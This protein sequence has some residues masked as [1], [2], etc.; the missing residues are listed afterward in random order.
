MPLNKNLA[1]EIMAMVTLDQKARKDSVKRKGLRSA[2]K[3]IDRKNTKE[4]IRI[5]EKYGWPTIS[6]VGEK[7]S[8]GAWLIAQHADQEI[9]FQKRALILLKKNLKDITKSNIAYLTDRI[10]INQKKPQL[11]GTQFTKSKNNLFIPLPIIKAKMVNERRRYYG[12]PTIES[13][14]KRINREWKRLGGT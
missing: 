8:N 4:L 12:M 10:L 13:N 1:K 5:I 7:A 11:F 3:K 9:K 6:L 14:V 2:Y